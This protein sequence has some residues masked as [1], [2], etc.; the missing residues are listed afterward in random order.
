MQKGTLSYECL[1]LATHRPRYVESQSS[2]EPI[3]PLATS[4]FCPT[5]VEATPARQDQP[6][7]RAESNHE[8]TAQSPGPQQ[9]QHPITS[10]Q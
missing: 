10:L 3:G 8:E 9:Q 4:P 2:S 7:G 5:V 1:E 6:E